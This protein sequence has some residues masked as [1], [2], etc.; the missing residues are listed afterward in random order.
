[1]R[2]R[3]LDCFTLCADLYSIDVRP[4]C[5]G[6]ELSFGDEQFA[7]RF[8]RSR[9][10]YDFGSTW[11]HSKAVSCRLNEFERAKDETKRNATTSEW[12]KDEN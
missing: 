3:T 10:L 7:E 1:M 6:A 9:D 5:R 4:L 12:E 8:L 2:Q 11:K